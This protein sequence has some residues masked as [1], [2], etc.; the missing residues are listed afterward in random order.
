MNFL[1]DPIDLGVLLMEG[2]AQVKAWWPEGQL[3][4]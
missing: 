3:K 2:T 1:T 4:P